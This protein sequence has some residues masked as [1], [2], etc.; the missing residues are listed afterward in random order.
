MRAVTFVLMVA[1]AL[2]GLTLAVSNALSQSS[3]LTAKPEIS[4]L[5]G[6]EFRNRGKSPEV[7][8]MLE[9]SGD[10]CSAGI[11]AIDGKTRVWILLRSTQPPMV[12]KMPDLDY[13]IT[14]QELDRLSSE[15]SVSNEV[16]TELRSHLEPAASSKSR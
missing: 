5:Q 4:L 10:Y 8:L 16:S 9:K 11:I 13:R 3:E 14:R 15:C 6:V 1:I 12:K 7:H 2:A